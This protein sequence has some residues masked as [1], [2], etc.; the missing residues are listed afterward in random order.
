MVRI[1]LLMVALLCFRSRVVKGLWLEK[2]GRGF[3][4]AFLDS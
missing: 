1:L 3:V 2:M 4:V